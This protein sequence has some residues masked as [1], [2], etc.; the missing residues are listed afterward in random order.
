[1]YFEVNDAMPKGLMKPLQ[2]DDGIL[3]ITF[4][5]DVD[6]HDEWSKS[7]NLTMNTGSIIW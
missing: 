7:T 3:I 2:I 1:M 4:G 6:F 5:C